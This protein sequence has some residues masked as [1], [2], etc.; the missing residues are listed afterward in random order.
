[1]PNFIN[2]ARALGR[3]LGKQK[4]CSMFGNDDFAFTGF[5]ADVTPTSKK[6]IVPNTYERLLEM[7]DRVDAFITLSN[8]LK[9]QY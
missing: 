8:G 6:E 9:N 3:V 5:V 4:I 7:N 1:M 2:I